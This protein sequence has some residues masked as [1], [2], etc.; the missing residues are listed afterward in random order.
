MLDHTLELAQGRRDA[1][2]ELVLAEEQR[3]RLVS[4][5]CGLAFHAG[6]LGLPQGYER[7][8]LV[9]LFDVC[10]ADLPWEYTLDQWGDY[11]ELY[12]T[13]VRITNEARDG[14]VARPFPQP[15]RLD[16]RRRRR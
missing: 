8:V 6:I 12:D 2:A 9:M 1:T 14:L 4:L 15:T 13:D 11:V 5:L 7:T 3:D 16:G 10:G